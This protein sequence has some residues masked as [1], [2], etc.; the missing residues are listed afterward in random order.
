MRTMQLFVTS[1]VILNKEHAVKHALISKKEMKKYLIA[2]F[3]VCGAL[4]AS[5][6]NDDEEKTLPD[7]SPNNVEIS[8]GATGGTKTITVNNAKELNVTQ[9]NDKVTTSSSTKEVNVL[10]VDN[11]G[12][13]NSKQVTEG[14]W[15]TISVEQVDGVYK[16]LIFTAS[17]NTDTQNTRQKFVH[18][19]CGG[20]IY[21]IAFRVEQSKGTSSN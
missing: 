13:K 6:S 15:I 9:I 5:C 14:G 12:I 16:K 17:E 1:T 21:G 4:F 11:G 8:F 18:V 2:L 7:I 20:N 19:S 10:S 3:A